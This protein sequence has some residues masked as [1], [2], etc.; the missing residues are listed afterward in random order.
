MRKTLSA[1]LFLACIVPVFSQEY[2]MAAGAGLEFN[3]QSRIYYAGGAS[4]TFDYNLPGPAA[5]GITITGS[6]NFKDLYIVDP[7]FFIRGYIFGGNSGFFVQY[8]V[9]ATFITWEDKT[10]EVWP[11]A[12]IG[13][14]Y[15]FLLG[16]HFYVEP[17]GR[18]GYP[19][20]LGIGVMGGMR[21]KR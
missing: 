14:G 9:G 3:M 8:G 1:A 21:F 12:G 6:M 13:A 7:H 18:F 20:D 16:D 10:R 15:R 4:L 5:L 11:M 2:K 19:F 17:Y